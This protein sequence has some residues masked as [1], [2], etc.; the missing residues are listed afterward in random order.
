MAVAAP[1]NTP[2]E[3]ARKISDAIGQAFKTPEL[4]ARILSLEAEP[5]GN[6]PEEMRAMIRASEQLWGPV[7]TAAKIS[8]D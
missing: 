1:A 7:V 4:R 8:V 3:I 2:K 5:L 6:T